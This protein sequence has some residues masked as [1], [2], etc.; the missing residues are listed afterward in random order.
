MRKAQCLVRMCYFDTCE[1]PCELN[2]CISPIFERTTFKNSHS[3]TKYPSCPH[4]RL[5]SIPALFENHTTSDMTTYTVLGATGNVGQSL[6]EVLMQSPDRQIHAYAR[7]KN[8]L[9]RLRPDLASNPQVKI[10]EGN[11][12]DRDMLGSCLS[13]T[14]EA[15][16]EGCGH[17][18]AT[19]HR[20]QL[21]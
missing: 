5:S 7:S 11:L 13:G 8:K 12:A 6:L 1:A 20:A 14:H 18:D 10:F 16:R 19:T 21:R 9:L 17:E 15:A 3:S 2:G 4:T